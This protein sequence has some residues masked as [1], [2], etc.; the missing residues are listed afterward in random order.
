VVV[1][2]LFESLHH[3]ASP[4]VLFE[5]PLVRILTVTI[6]AIG[7]GHFAVFPPFRV[8]LAAGQ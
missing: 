5:L 4:A 2:A 8:A 6:A 7:K 3:V 1:G